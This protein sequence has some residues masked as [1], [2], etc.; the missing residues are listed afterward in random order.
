MRIVLGNA[1]IA[2]YPHGGGHLSWFLQFLLGLRALG[3][4]VWWLEILKSAGDPTRDRD[5]IRGFFGRISPYGL[6][7]DCALMLVADS[8]V[9]DLGAAEFFGRSR[10]DLDEVIASADLLW[11]LSCSIRVPLLSRFR[12][13]VLIDGDPGHLQVSALAWD[14]GIQ[15]H[16]V[17]MTVGAKMNDPDCEVP[18]LGLG[19]RTFMPFVHLPMWEFAPD[20]GPA[21][22][23]S[24]IT[25]WTWE[26]LA[27]GD[28]ML[29]AGKRAG[30]L[31][32]A[33]LARMAGRPCE[34]AANIGAA[35][36]AGDRAR[37]TAGGWKLADPHAVVSTPEAYRDYIRRSRGEILCPKPIYRELRTGWF[38]DR[39]VCYLASGRPVVAEETGFSERI[40]TGSGLLA[41]KDPAGAAEAIRA[42]DTD[43][44]AHSRAAR[45]LACEIFDAR[46]CLAAMIE[47]CE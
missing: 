3:H 6:A 17:L 45:E 9:Q 41:F 16:D 36:P 7:D 19:W 20:P 38:S 13:T 33:D 14:L 46:R 30:Y 8:D 4:D 37:F 11:N 2:R 27:L 39:S 47:A 25:Q 31:P 21:A 32:Y 5:N 29:G 35:D 15:R 24:S 26:E 10:A 18:K 44:A 34:L 43:Y 42:I 28:R 22:P 1:S 23:F 40:P 12:K